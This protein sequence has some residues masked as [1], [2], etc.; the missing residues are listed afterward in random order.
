L[1]TDRELAPVQSPGEASGLCRG[2]GPRGKGVG[3]PS[4][5]GR[6]HAVVHAS[7]TRLGSERLSFAGSWEGTCPAAGL[8]GGASLREPLY[9]RG[10]NNGAR[11]AP[12]GG[13]AL[14]PGSES[15]IIP[16]S[17]TACLTSQT[18]VALLGR[19]LGDHVRKFPTG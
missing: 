5:P 12:L 18:T 6:R 14:S 16:R 3:T 9:T 4:P 2:S 13:G 8:R 11:K 19:H 1:R 7:G 10:G 17:P 15:K